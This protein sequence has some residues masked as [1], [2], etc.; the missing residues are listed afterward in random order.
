MMQ[1]QRI[2]TTKTETKL[3]TLIKMQSNQIEYQ[4]RNPK[5]NKM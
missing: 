2:I 5:I 3:I 1:M 4:L